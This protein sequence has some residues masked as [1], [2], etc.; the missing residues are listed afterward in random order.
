MT[1]RLAQTAH[2]AGQVGLALALLSDFHER[3]QRSPH[4]LAAARAAGVT[5]LSVHLIFAAP[6]QRPEQWARDLS[7]VLDLARLAD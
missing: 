6:G 1:W 2:Q 5:N 4:L 3:F 7:R